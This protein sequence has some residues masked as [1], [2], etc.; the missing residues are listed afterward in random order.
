MIY[1]WDE[2]KREINLAKHGVDFA[3]IERFDWRDAVVVPSH[4][5]GE[6]R[7]VAYGY[8]DD[9]MHAVVFTMR[10]GNTR[11]ISLRRANPEEAGHET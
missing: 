7:F 2:G 10:L 8:L 11:I 9:R 5:G 1:E 4:R 3:A 6:E